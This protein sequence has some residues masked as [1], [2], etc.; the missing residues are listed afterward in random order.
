M[1]SARHG[2]M[3]PGTIRSSKGYYTSELEQAKREGRIKLLPHDPQLLVQT[4]WDLGIDDAMCIAFVQRT[5]QET[6]VIDHYQAEGFGF[7]HYAGK[8][9][10]F[11]A[12][13]KYL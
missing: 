7:D 1:A 3:A 2:A 11:A 9:Q 5:S 12:E 6:R 4:L 10:Q 8:L 13:K